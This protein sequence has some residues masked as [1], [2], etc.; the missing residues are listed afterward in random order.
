MH[1]YTYVR[2]VLEILVAVGTLAVAVLAIWGQKIRSVLA[3]PKLVIEPH[4]LSGDPTVLRQLDNPQ[5]PGTRVM[6]Y[7]LKV[8][9]K[10]PW[11]P[12]SSCRVVLKGLTKR[13]P[14]NLFHPVTMPVPLQF[15][16][17]PAEITPPTVTIT[18]EHVL[19]FGRIVEGGKCFQPVLYSYLN[20]FQGFVCPREAVRYQLEVQAADFTSPRHHVFEVAWDGQWSHVPEEMLKH[21]TIREL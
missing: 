20:N 13:G 1:W 7:H 8:V 2:V 6:Y 15:V 3:P 10:R 11:L 4:N 5:A 19:D 14:D 21:L 17:A 16:W 18:K 12:V 9:N